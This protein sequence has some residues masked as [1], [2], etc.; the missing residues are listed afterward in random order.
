[1]KR[2][3]RF[4]FTWLFK[5]LLCEVS[6]TDIKKDLQFHLRMEKQFIEELLFGP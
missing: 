2:I 6:H 5:Q 1:M 3:K 4:I